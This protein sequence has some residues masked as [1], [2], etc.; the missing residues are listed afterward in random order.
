MYIHWSIF[1]IVIHFII[2][3]AISPKW[4]IE[5]NKHLRH[6][7]SLPVV[8]TPHTGSPVTC[9]ALHGEPWHEDPTVLAATTTRDTAPTT[10]MLTL[11]TP[12]LDCIQLIHFEKLTGANFP[13][14]RTSVAEFILAA[15]AVLVSPQPSMA[16]RVITNVMWLQP[17]ESST[18]FLH[19]AHVFQP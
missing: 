17:M 14:G 2:I 6:E 16:K 12:V 1:S 4:G 9:S 8:P 19:L 13:W 3:F 11:Y 5:R 10:I 15:A 18:R 7:K